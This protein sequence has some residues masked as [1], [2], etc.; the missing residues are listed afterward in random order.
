MATIT[1]N[2]PGGMGTAREVRRYDVGMPIPVVRSDDS[3]TSACTSP[4][5]RVSVG[6][7]FEGMVGHS[8]AMRRLFRT[9][10]RVAPTPAT[11]LVAGETGTGK[12]LVA[13]AIHAMSDRARKRFVAVN[14]SAIP[15]T[16]L[17]SELFGHERG[18]FTGAIQ[19]R[20][21]WIQAAAGGTLFL[22][23]VS[24]L[25]ENIQVKLLRVI[26]ERVIHPIGS[27]V[28]IPVDFRLVV[29]T[30]RDLAELVAK[31]R[32]RKDVYYRLNVF[33]LRIPPL[34]ER[35]EDLPLLTHHFRVRF[36]TA[37]GLEPP[38]IGHAVFSR[39]L[40][41]G[42]PGNVRELENFVERC[43]IL[44]KATDPAALESLHSPSDPVGVLLERALGERWTLD[45][46]EREYVLST[47]AV[48]GGSQAEAARRLGVHPAAI[49]RRLK[50]YREEGWAH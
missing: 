6:L 11:V 10:S 5:R 13:R 24:T 41:Y 35:L 20:R 22:D 36:S 16:L 8:P 31:G 46:L 17:D 50:R 26:Q 19:S 37:L 39:M 14:C 2:G 9:I 3:P 18:A 32:F 25:S 45:R 28:P 15:G 23:E 44:G 29:A 4:S 40:E 48:T 12:E 38:E 33:P 47:L 34:R 21:G 43:V 42:W 1:P 30:N 49:C 27:R 7:A